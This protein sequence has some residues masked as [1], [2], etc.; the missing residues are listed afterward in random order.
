[1]SFQDSFL[2][3]ED[4][5]ILHPRRLRG[6]KL[7][8]AWTV[9]LFCV[10]FYIGSWYYFVPNQLR[11]SHSGRLSANFQLIQNQN[12][13]I[14][15]L[16]MW[17]DDKN[18]EKCTLTQIKT[19]SGTYDV[20]L[21]ATVYQV[22]H[23]WYDKIGNT[24]HLLFQCAGEDELRVFSTILSKDLDRALSNLKW[25]YKEYD[26]FI[27]GLDLVFIVVTAG[28]GFLLAWRKPQDWLGLY[29]SLTLI[30][31]AVSQSLMLQQAALGLDFW[32]FILFGPPLALVHFSFYIFPDGK[33]PARWAIFPAA[34]VIIYY[35]ARM[36]FQISGWAKEIDMGFYIF[37]IGILSYRYRKSTSPIE[38][39]QIKWVIWGFGL[40]V[41]G[42]FVPI[43]IHDSIFPLFSGAE[44]W[45]TI[46]WEFFL[47]PINKLSVSIPAITLVISMLRTGLWR[48]NYIISRSTAYVAA[49]MSLG[50]I[51]IF[52]LWSFTRIAESLSL[53]KLPF[54]FVV[55]LFLFLLFGFKPIRQ[56]L[57][58]WVDRVFFGI[59]IPYMAEQPQLP[60]LE[61]RQPIFSSYSG[62]TLI[63]SGGMSEVYRAWHESERQ[64]VAIKILARNLPAHLDYRSRFLR[65]ASLLKSF[66]HPNII[67]VFEYGEIDDVPYMVMEYMDGGNLG[68]LLSKSPLMLLEQALS[69]L[70][71]LASALDY[72]H[73]R[74]VLHRD[75]KPQNIMLKAGQPIL[76]D[77]GIAKRLYNTLSKT[78]AD[79]LGTVNYMSPEQIQADPE[80]GAASDLYSFGVLTYQMLTG[81]LPFR[82]GNA[83]A[84]LLAHINQPPPNPCE[85]NPQL[86]PMLGFVVQ[87]MLAKQPDQ[88]FPSASAFIN[89][90]QQAQ[91]NAPAAT[92]RDHH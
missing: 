2:D 34:I 1:M 24:V 79:L 59:R 64:M 88:R 31:M 56:W 46:L 38:R 53:N 23:H 80:I 76:M 41:F 22:R 67:H 68:D 86:P 62:L 40:A 77:F 71:A 63:G 82:Y 13:T 5:K 20:P 70:G 65:E 32:H 52:M 25:S 19:E 75:I 39:T 11:E 61:F 33:L 8:A 4:T 73:A 7:F 17:R 29:A 12:G 21:N 58:G 49:A 91:I 66:E 85:I 55:I 3:D 48:V 50:L 30:L 6:K 42:V 51:F 60:R 37:E 35:L 45:K 18:G 57:Q 14:S 44:S 84:V 74:G 10:I 47:Q 54:Y 89:A 90:L 78:P 36:A 16:N 9:W 26:R 43:I 28:V 92:S 72:I 15:F 87:R 83:G 69:M 81:Q 27:F